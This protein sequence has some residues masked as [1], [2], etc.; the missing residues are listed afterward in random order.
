MSDVIYIH[1]NCRDIK[2]A[3]ELSDFLIEAKLIA[4][5]NILAPHHAVLEWEGQYCFQEEVG[6]FLKTLE[7]NYKE[8]E[9]VLLAKHSYDCPCI[10]YWKVDGG[11]YPYMAWVEN[12]TT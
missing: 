9:R 4:C 6:M 1:V 10:T 5:S 3:K 2:E 12:K 7:K 8:I 11:Y